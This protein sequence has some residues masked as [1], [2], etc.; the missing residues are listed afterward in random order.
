M[1][2][3]GVAITLPP[4]QGIADNARVASLEIEQSWTVEQAIFHQVSLPLNNHA[5]RHQHFCLALREIRRAAKRQRPAS[6]GGLVAGRVE[7][8]CPEPDL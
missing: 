4:H 6:R 2:L 8:D 7:Q 1:T 3:A 5:K